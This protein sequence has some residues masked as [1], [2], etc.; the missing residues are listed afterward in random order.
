[1]AKQTALQKISIVFEETGVD[2]AEGK[3]FNV[4][5]HGHTRNLNNTKEDD[6][7]PAEFWASRCFAIVGDVLKKTGAVEKVFTRPDGGVGH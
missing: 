1:M 3:R 6:L 4:Y 5:L 7:S 2:T